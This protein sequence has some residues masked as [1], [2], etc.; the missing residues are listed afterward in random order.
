M[1]AVKRDARRE[2][3]AQT[4]TRILDA[5]YALW[6]EHGYRATT[7]QDIA[8][9]A[10][11]AVQTTYFSFRTKDSLLQAV[12]D[13]TV[14]GEDGQPP[15]HQPWYTAA[16]AAPAI[17]DAVATLVTGAAGIL[18]RVAP[19]LPV[20]ESVSADPAGA[21]FRRGEQLRRDSFG[22]L[23][24]LLERTAPL[25]PGLSYAHAVDLLFVLLGPPLYRSL[26]IE[27][28]WAEHEWAAWVTATLL[29]DLF[30]RAVPPS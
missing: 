26:V 18:A 3:S 5:A 6:C 25:R 30:G 4:R 15:E 7:M 27:S 19:M 13:R 9:R 17:D 23:V 10:G 21:V 28:G 14:L 22:K 12:H 1:K 11:V 16:I 2:K 24:T 8:D 29:R 20:F